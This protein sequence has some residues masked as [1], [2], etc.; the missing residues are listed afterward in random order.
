MWAARDHA[1]EVM[2]GIMKGR[3]LEKCPPGVEHLQV[4]V[5]KPE[6]TGIV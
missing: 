6:V 1:G 3:P 2:P 5:V 4:H